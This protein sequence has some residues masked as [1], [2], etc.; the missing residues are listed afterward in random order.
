MFKGLKS[1]L[2]EVGKLY[3]ELSS[4][5]G[6]RDAALAES[7]ERGLEA[8]PILRQ[9]LGPYVPRPNW[10]L[11]WGGL[12][13]IGGLSSFIQSMSLEH[14][15]NSSFKRDFRILENGNE[16]T[17]LARVTNAFAPLIGINAT[18]KEIMKGNMQGSLR[19][20][21]TTTYDLNLSA[22]N[23]V[24][25]F[26]REISFQISYSRRGFQLPLFGLNLNNDID[27]TFSFSQSKNSRR[28][29]DPTLL[30]S[31]QDG[32]PL[33]GTTRTTLEPRIKYVL[34][35]RVSA[36][37]FYKYTSIAPDEG[38]S[39]IPGTSTNEAGLDIHISIQ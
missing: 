9:L 20:G 8:L 33:D 14:G 23:I 1:N 22:Q 26:S 6:R 18:F 25:T 16:A 15:Y 5:P 21:T 30:E 17:D 36:S 37:L 35:S 27:M 11:S 10:S 39:T 34:S 12:E 29:H 3:G 24:E 2:E 28:Q 19:F 32:T 13:K 4:D 7:F 38:A 31:N